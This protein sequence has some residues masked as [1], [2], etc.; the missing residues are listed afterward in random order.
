MPRITPTILACYVNGKPDASP[1]ETT[2]PDLASAHAAAAGRRAE[3]EAA[4]VE[5]GPLWDQYQGDGAGFIVPAGT[6]AGLAGAV[7][8]PYSAPYWHGTGARPAPPI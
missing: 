3:L 7:T 4:N 5:V 2:W 8:E 1:H 6:A